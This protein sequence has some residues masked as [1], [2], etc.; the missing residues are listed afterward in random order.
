MITFKTPKGT[1][2]PFINLKGKQYLQVMHRLVWFREEHP[3]WSIETE[4]VTQVEAFAVAKCTIRND[5][6][7]IVSQ[8][9]GREDKGHFPDYI[10]KAETKAVGRALGYCGY[11]TQF[12]PEFDEQERIVDAPRPAPY[13]PPKPMTPKPNPDIY[14]STNEQK[15]ALV[16]AV[17]TLTAPGQ[18][19]EKLAGADKDSAFLQALDKSLQGEQ[20][21]DVAQCIHNA[22]AEK[23]GKVR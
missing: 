12:A 18:A 7:H 9:H 17:K 4:I 15:K 19:F 1:E 11:G 2:L 21:A 20:M 3:E 14:S 16:N 5:K 6:G 23:L 8:A 10:E 22:L 13:V